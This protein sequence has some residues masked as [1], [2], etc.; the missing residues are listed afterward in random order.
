MT[1]KRSA[2]GE[3]LCYNP[4]VLRLSPA[5]PVTYRR[6][7][8]QIRTDIPLT[9]LP[10]FAYSPDTFL[11]CFPSILP[12]RKSNLNALN[13]KLNARPA[14]LNTRKSNLNVQEGKTMTTHEFNHSI[15]TLHSVVIRCKIMNYQSGVYVYARMLA[16][17]VMRE[18]YYWETVQEEFAASLWPLASR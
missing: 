7:R 3:H 10:R 2:Q 15:D 5:S 18:G 1:Q 8:P 4:L 14:S 12:T 13:T 16:R 11:P 17:L 9:V 6:S